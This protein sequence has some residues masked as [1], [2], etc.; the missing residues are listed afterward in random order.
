MTGRT[1]STVPGL[2]SHV[3]R[4][5]TD[6]SPE[7]A[8]QDNR[9]AGVEHDAPGIMKALLAGGTGRIRRSGTTRRAC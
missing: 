2:A 9:I 4:F 7:E 1:G 8:A 6:Y 5:A 3:P